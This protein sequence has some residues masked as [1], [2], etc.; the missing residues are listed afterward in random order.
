MSLRFG[1]CRSNT[2]H[3]SV[4][5]ERLIGTEVPTVEDLRLSLQVTK[6]LRPSAARDGAQVGLVTYGTSRSFGSHAELGV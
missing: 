4:S 3:L 6:N 2:I 5:P 1:K